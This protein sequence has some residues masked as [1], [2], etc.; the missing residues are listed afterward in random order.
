MHSPDYDILSDD[1]LFAGYIDSGI[2]ELEEWLAA[3]DRQR[4]H[5]R[6]SDTNFP[7]DSEE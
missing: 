5:F 3:G 6:L 1:G 2:F 7:S 4:E